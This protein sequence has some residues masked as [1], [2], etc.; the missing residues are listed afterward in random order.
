MCE[1]RWVDIDSRVHGA[2]DLR[3]QLSLDLGKIGVGHHLLDRLW[4]VTGLVDKRGHG[5]RTEHRP[6]TKAVVLGVERQVHTEIEARV[7]P[8]PGGGIGEPRAR[9]H[10]APAGCGTG[11]ESREPSL[12]GGM[13]HAEIIDMNHRGPR[14]VVVQAEIS[15][16]GHGRR[17]YATR[18]PRLLD[19]R[20]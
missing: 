14:D 1:S 17:S 2:I 9:H 4:E 16:S 20:S 8:G 6:P 19:T 7:G 11:L 13:G 3:P 18:N 15:E 12:I 5:G 10:D